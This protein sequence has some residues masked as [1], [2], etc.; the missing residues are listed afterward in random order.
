MATATVP[1][2]SSDNNFETIQN[3]LYSN[4]EVTVNTGKIP[5][6]PPDANDKPI[7]ILQKNLSQNAIDFIKNKERLI[8]NEAKKLKIKKSISNSTLFDEVLHDKKKQSEK[9]K[10]S[11]ILD[12]T[13]RELSPSESTKF[14]L[15]TTKTFYIIDGVSCGSVA[16]IFGFKVGDI[17]VGMYNTNGNVKELFNYNDEEALYNLKGN[18]IYDD[19]TLLYINIRVL[20]YYATTLNF[21][22]LNINPIIQLPYDNNNVLH[23]GRRFILP[24]LNNPNNTITRFGSLY[25]KKYNK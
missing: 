9:Q 16:A 10:C 2:S 15:D 11:E 19:R 18:N 12:F 7:K 13:L 24:Y 21:D 22:Y 5:E 20:R 25:F 17:I 4:K 1:V 23:H 3:M 6:S 14:G 8:E